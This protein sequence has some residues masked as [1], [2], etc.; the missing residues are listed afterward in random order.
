VW[1]F[2]T[3]VAETDEEARAH[4]AEA[5][6]LYVATRLYAKRQTYDDILRSGLGLLGGVETVAAKLAAL[7]R[8]GIEHVMTLTSFGG[9]AED[10]VAR[11][12]KLMMERVRPRA[13]ALLSA[14]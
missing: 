7:S 1:A 8:M 14:A 3:Y 13:K 10:K 4:A 11:S 2:H 9:L 12:M 6:D 5:F